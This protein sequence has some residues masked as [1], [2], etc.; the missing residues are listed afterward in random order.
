ML[1]TP[2]SY[3]VGMAQS[4]RTQ[5]PNR[6][7][8]R[9]LGSDSVKNLLS[10]SPKKS[11]PMPPPTNTSLDTRQATL[12]SETDS[13]TNALYS[14]DSCNTGEFIPLHDSPALTA[15]PAVLTSEPAFN[16]IVTGDAKTA[17]AGL[18]VASVSLSFWSPP[19]YVGKSYE[20]HLSF[21]DWQELIREVIHCHRR[22]IQ[23]GGFM[24]VNIGDILCFPDESMPRFQADNV[25][26]KKVA[27][28]KEQIL[29]TKQ[30]HPDANRHDLAKLLGCSEQTIQRRLEDNNVRGGKH[31]A[32]TKIKLTGC[33][34]AEWAEE[35]GFYLY[36][37]RIW[38]KD[39]CWANSRWHS[40][41]Y[42]A[43]DEFEH[44]Y[45]FWK[46][47]ITEYDRHRLSADEWAEW[48]SRGVWQIPSV[49]RND[50]HEAE[51]PEELAERVIRLFSPVGGVV[52][53]P[54]VGTG[55][56]TTVANRLGRQW[57]GIDNNPAHTEIASQR[58]N[59][60]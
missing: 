56:T 43:V 3:Y 39:P 49:R 37:Q 8:M 45:V 27:V 44:V 36:D 10:V 11:K 9:Y 23:P 15:I 32:S 16:H 19:Y 60:A 50:R 48:G 28:T 18:P 51:F 26:R 12:L 4:L 42:R 2:P 30:K 55:T 24:A 31:T 25:R 38:H 22:I 53:D 35:A 29:E 57:I 13:F 41:S 58:T 40:N 20:R 7:Q 34:V 54:F 47:G 17:L 52:L 1:V 14:F 33:L 46:P 59:E 6:G 5:H 21:E